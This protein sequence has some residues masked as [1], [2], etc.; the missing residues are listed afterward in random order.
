MYSVLIKLIDHLVRY[1]W[2]E[3]G[4][5][6]SPGPVPCSANVDEHRQKRECCL[7]SR[8]DAATSARRTVLRLF[9]TAEILTEVRL[10]CSEVDN[11][12]HDDRSH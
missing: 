2:L 6:C 5:R 11:E 12:N 10:V 8:F 1:T 4:P 7:C 3:D 9:Q